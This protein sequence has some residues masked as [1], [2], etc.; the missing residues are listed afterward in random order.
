MRSIGERVALINAKHP[1]RSVLVADVEHENGNAREVE[2]AL[3]AELG[4]RNST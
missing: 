3:M 4:M 1:E 2:G